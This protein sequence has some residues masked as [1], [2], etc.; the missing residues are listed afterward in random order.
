MINYD[1]GICS[2][3]AIL[4]RRLM[5]KMETKVAAAPMR[6]KRKNPILRT[7]LPTLPTRARSRVALGLTAAAA[8]GALELQICRDCGTVQYPPREVCGGCL[9][10]RLVWRPQNG[11][12]ELVAE[13]VLH[14]AQELYFRERL[15]WR[16]GMVRLDSGANLVVYLQDNVGVAPCRVRV[17]AALDRAGEAI[18]SPY[19]QTG[20]LICPPIRSCV[21]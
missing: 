4:G 8:R 21:R 11:E 10:S 5:R 2:G 18:C 15:P 7:P 14:A 17:E 9:S 19:P 1:R 6:A 12:G 3:A 16:I 20:G 13:T